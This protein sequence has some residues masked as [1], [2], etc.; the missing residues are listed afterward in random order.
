[1]AEEQFQ[2]NIHDDLDDLLKEVADAHL[3]GYS[4]ACP[5][6]QAQDTDQLLTAAQKKRRKKKNKKKEKQEAA[7]AT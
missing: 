4:K 5:P 2:S 1:M 6:L 3:P 7:G